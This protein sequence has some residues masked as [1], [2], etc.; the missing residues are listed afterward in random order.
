MWCDVAAESKTT[1][2]EFV[3]ALRENIV[4]VGFYVGPPIFCKRVTLLVSSIAINHSYRCQ[5]R[6]VFESFCYKYYQTRFSWNHT[7]KV[8]GLCIGFDQTL[9]KIGRIS[10]SSSRK[11]SWYE[12]FLP[13]RWKLSSLQNSDYQEIFQY[14]IH[15]S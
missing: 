7:Y 4:R 15:Q 13:S 12:Y 8:I 3:V 6:H 2:H 11:Q 5:W 10:N 14:R 9:T 1:E